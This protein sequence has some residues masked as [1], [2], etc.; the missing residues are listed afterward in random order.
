M[1][2][3]CLNIFFTSTNSVGPDEMQHYAAFHLVFTVCKC[4][5]LGVYEYKGLITTA[6]TVSR[7]LMLGMQ[8]VVAALVH[9]MV[10]KT[11]SV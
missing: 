4:I 5:C 6:V 11:F 10:R 8:C 9:C 1:Y 2:H 3:F 7:P